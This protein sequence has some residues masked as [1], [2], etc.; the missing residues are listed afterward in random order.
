M[1]QNSKASAAIGR[2][3]ALKTSSFLMLSTPK[4]TTNILSNQKRK[5]QMA[6]PV[7]SVHDAGNICGK[8][9]IA[10]I[11]NLAIR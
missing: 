2:K 6:G 11:H 7:C 10:G 3:N 8:V 9:S 4:Y 5:K 1:A